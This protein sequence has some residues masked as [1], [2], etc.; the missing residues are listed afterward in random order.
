MSSETSDPELI[1]VPGRDHAPLMRSCPCGSLIDPDVQDDKGR[2][3]CEDCGDYFDGETGAP[4]P[5]PD[6]MG[7]DR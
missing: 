6:E 7:G 4:L 1:E 3:W 5:H 2:V